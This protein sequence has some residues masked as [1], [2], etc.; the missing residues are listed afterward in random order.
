MKIHQILLSIICAM[1]SVA[2]S[3]AALDIG[4]HDLLNIGQ[5]N[6]LRDTSTLGGNSF[7]TITGGLF[8]TNNANEASVIGG[9]I[10]NIIP[11]TNVHSSVIGGGYVNTIAGS[12]RTHLIN[13]D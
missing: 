3:F 4:V 9:G 10:L 8:N 7:N 2:S 12:T 5:D 1:A 6:F 13:S 11:D